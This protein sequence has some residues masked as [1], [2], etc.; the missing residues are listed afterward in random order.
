MFRCG[1]CAATRWI[2]A[3]VSSL[4][5]PSTNMISVPCPM[6][7][8]RR[9]ASSI[10]PDSLRAGMTTEQRYCC[11]VAGCGRGRAITPTVTQKGLT[12][13]DVD[14]DRNLLLI[15]GA[16]PGANGGLLLIKSREQA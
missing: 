12:V 13:V 1:Y 16:V 5:W 7:G 8:V 4:E 11:T 15:R 9:T 6:S 14:A 2:S 10:L 3:H